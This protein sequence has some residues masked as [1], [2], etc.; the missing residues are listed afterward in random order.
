MTPVPGAPQGFASADLPARPSPRLALVA[1]VPMAATGFETN[2]EG[3][4]G[5][6]DER[7]GLIEFRHRPSVSRSLSLEEMDQAIADAFSA[8]ADHASDRVEA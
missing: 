2:I 4:V 6:K 3:F 5:R 7:F 1:V 8:D